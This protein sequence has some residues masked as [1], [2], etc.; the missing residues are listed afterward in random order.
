MKRSVTTPVFS[1]CN[2]KT[3]SLPQQDPTKLTKLNLRFLKK[4][5]VISLTF[6][7]CNILNTEINCIYINIIKDTYYSKFKSK[8]WQRIIGFIADPGE[9]KYYIRYNN[10]TIGNIKVNTLKATIKVCAVGL[11]NW[12]VEDPIECPASFIDPDIKE[13]N[14]EI[15]QAIGICDEDMEKELGRLYKQFRIETV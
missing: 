6:K 15:L 7:G 3:I 13:S 8:I 2:N 14:S 1:N 12:V 5:P 9:E 4:S 10:Q 11:F